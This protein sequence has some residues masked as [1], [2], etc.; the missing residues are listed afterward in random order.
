MRRRMFACLAFGA[1]PAALALGGMPALAQK[2]P[3]P[4]GPA[5][6]APPAGGQTAYTMGEIGRRVRY[7]RQGAWLVQATGDGALTFANETDPTAWTAALTAPPGPAYAVEVLVNGDI[8][9]VEG[10]AVGAGIVFAF[11]RGDGGPGRRYRVAMLAGD[12]LSVYRYADGGFARSVS[13][14]NGAWGGGGWHAMRL[15]VRPESFAIAMDGQQ[16]ASIG[17]GEPLSG[18]VG[19][20]VSG[21]GRAAFRE[22]RLG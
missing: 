21:T 16:V 6:A 17:D 3:P 14:R 5:P 2:A 18:E 20:M 22:L 11:Q 7:G 8:P 10:H 1:A 4:A 9:A 12:T 13:S 15:T 19:V